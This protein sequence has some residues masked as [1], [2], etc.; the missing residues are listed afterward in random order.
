MG[1]ECPC[2]P[3][4]GFAVRIPLSHL[5]VHENSDFDERIN[6]RRRIDAKEMNAISDEVGRNSL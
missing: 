4:Q 5:L 6:F 3:F 2:E 1:I